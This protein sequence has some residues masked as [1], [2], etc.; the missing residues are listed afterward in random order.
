MV[1]TAALRAFTLI[2]HAAARR[3][4]VKTLLLTLLVF[5]LLAVGLWAGFHALRLHYG[6]GGGGLAEAA[7]A[8]APQ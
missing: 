1:L 4:L 2:F 8:L 5:A 3:L 7:P 6:W